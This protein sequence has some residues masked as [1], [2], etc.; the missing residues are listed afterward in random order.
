MKIKVGD[1]VESEFGCGKVLAT[2][3]RWTIHDDSGNGRP[4]DEYAVFLTD[5]LTLVPIDDPEENDSI[6]KE[7]EVEQ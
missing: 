4:E 1:I 5:G 6:S 2:T 7:I 3:K